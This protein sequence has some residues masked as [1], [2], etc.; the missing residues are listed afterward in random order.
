MDTASKLHSFLGIF[1]FVTFFL[2][3]LTIFLRD[4]ILELSN[5]KFQHQSFC[6][7]ASQSATFLRNEPNTTRKIS[8]K[9]E[10]RQS[11]YIFIFK[12]VELVFKTI[13]I[14]FVKIYMHNVAK[15][16]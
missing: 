10:G 1:L 6:Q 8:Y 14:E 13:L 4:F 9:H 3:N 5:A 16:G 7:F 15:V 12:A 2:H 11:R